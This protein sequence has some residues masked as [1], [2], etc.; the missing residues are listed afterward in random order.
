M[1]SEPEVEIK[2]ERMKCGRPKSEIPIDKIAY[3]KKYYEEH[4][5]KFKGDLLCPHCKKLFSKS[6]KTRH[7]QKY[8]P[9]ILKKKSIL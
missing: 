3:R 1:E 9:E 5:E 8:H 2:Y 6:N 4:K 7:N